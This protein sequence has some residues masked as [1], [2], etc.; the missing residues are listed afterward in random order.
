MADP[1]RISEEAPHTAPRGGLL[2]PVLWLLL[3]VS[4]SA[5]A[6]SS[7]IGLHVLIGIGFGL[8]TVACIAALVAHHYLNRPPR[9][10]GH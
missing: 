7:A 9:P 2:R 4:A 6:V 3:I 10:A 5:N 1:Y 8:I